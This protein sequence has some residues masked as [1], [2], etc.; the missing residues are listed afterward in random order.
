MY[1]R[2]KLIKFGE[3]EYYFGLSFTTHH[4]DPFESKKIFI[5]IGLF[6]LNITFGPFSILLKSKLHI[7]VAILI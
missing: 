7:K 2:F 1:C 5:L 3:N 6:S 4:Y